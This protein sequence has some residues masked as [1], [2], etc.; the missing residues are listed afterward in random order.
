MNIGLPFLGNDDVQKYDLIFLIY[1][2][3]TTLFIPAFIPSNQKNKYF[4]PAVE[5][6]NA[7]RR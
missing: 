2:L 1:N 3:S 4:I 7:D 5:K 6:Q